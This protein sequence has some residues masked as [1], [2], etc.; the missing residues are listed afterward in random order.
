MISITGSPGFS[1][2]TPFGLIALIAAIS[3]STSQRM[4]SI[5]CTPELVIEFS[6]VNQSGAETLRCAQWNITARPSLPLF[7]VFRI[8]T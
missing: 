7:S 4:M 1:F 8:S 2:P 6:G 3:S 5:S